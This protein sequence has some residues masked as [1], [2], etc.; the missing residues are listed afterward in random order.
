MIRPA[1]TASIRSRLTLA[2]LTVSL[3][4]AVSI[5]LYFPPQLARLARGALVSKAVAVAEVLAYN[6]TAPLEFHDGRGAAETLASVAD[7]LDIA[8]VQV[9]DNA[10]RTV[11]GTHFYDALE[12]PPLATEVRERGAVLEVLSPIDGPGG[13]LGILVLRVDATRVQRDVARNRS[14]TWLVSLAVA[15]MGLATGRVVSRRITGPVSALSDAAEAMAEGRFDVRV[16]HVDSDELGR[17][18][19]AF[20]AMAHNVQQARR[21]VE[22]Y[23]RNLEA[24]VEIRTAELSAAKD[25][26]DRANRAKSQFL[27]NMSHEIRT[28]MNGIMG[29]TELTLAGKLDVE[30]RRNLT[31]VKDSAEALLSIINDILDFS[32]VEAGR[33]ELERIEFDLYTLLDGVTDTFGLETARQDLEF[34][35]NLDPRVPR[36]LAGDPGRLRQVLVNLLGNAVKF[37]AS[38]HV[39]L[40]VARVR[41]PAG[42]TA[43]RFAIND[44]GIGIP[45]ESCQTIFGAF[46][47]ADAST[48]RKYGG[49]GLGLAISSQLVS[50]M[51]GTL[52]VQSTVGEGSTFTFELAL[53]PAA[54]R[55]PHW[56]TAAGARAA[57]VCRHPASRRALA[58]QLS[59]LGW[60]TDDLS[61]DLDAPSLEAALDDG[62]GPL[63]LLLYDVAAM[64]LAGPAWRKVLQAAV[65]RARQ[66]V[67]L[68]M[69]GDQ[70]DEQDQG[71]DGQ[72]R[73]PAK[74]SSL[75]A[76]LN[77]EAARAAAVKA[78][79]DPA[80]DAR[81]LHGLRVLLVEDN[82]VNQTFARL[83]LAKLGCTTTIADHG[84]EGLEL[85]SRAT[86]DVVLSDVQMPIMD[87]LTMTSRIR[88]DEAGT[89][90]HVPIIGVTAHALQADRDRCLASGMDAYVSKPIRVQELVAA[91]T[92]VLA[93]PV[94]P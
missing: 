86:F 23:S 37:T 47:Q 46:S 6:L 9:L 64:R 42:A 17:L 88:A 76:V 25:A 4:G 90:G 55:D 67:P 33:L 11:A 72:L 50:L 27:A 73:L 28:P 82:P 24:M 20:N 16:N 19:G 13:R 79:T 12:R 89:G 5:A 85:L 1:S 2:I 61:A 75:Q 87:G 69:I 35:C 84:A 68:T 94:G 52:S 58:A 48:T 77:P 40:A 38:G 53:D 56:P 71:S 34:V 8:G 62:D 65:A 81:A 22:D 21:E 78:T 15:L 74:P 43:V 14:L 63:D 18:A 7:D 70:D 54:E 93:A 92:A 49:T 29:M 91:I 3:V 51:G 30:Q 83:L 59:R 39:E 57:V 60:A 66:S 26:A 31:I 10:Q 32:K 41:T 80:G 36:Q 45:A 44:T